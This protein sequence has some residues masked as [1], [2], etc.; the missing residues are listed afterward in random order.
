MTGLTVTNIGTYRAEYT[1]L[2]GCRSTSADL[3]VSAQPSGNLYVYPNPSSGQFQVRFYNS[4]NEQAT[5]SIYDQKGARVYSRVFNT[6]IPYTSLNVDIS[7]LAAGKYLVEVVNSAGRRI[8]AK[9][10][11]VR[12]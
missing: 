10:I 12:R 3:I 8:G 9:W 11:V 7:R 6:T 5:I 2:N 1:D 4:A